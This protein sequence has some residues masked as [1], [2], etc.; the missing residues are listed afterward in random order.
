MKNFIARLSL[1]KIITFIVAVAIIVSFISYLPQTTVH[2]AD[3]P[4]VETK[5]V[6][7]AEGSISIEADEL[8]IASNG[9]REMYLDPKTLNTRIVDIASG[10]EFNSV[11]FADEATEAEHAP[12]ILTYMDKSGALTQWDAFTH[13]ID[14][15]TYSIDRIANGY[16]ATLHFTASESTV[17]NEFMPKEMPLERYEDFF[18]GGIDRMVLDG[19]ITEAD[20]ERYQKALRMIYNVQDDGN[21]YYNKYSGT[22]PVS[23]TNILI[24]LSKKLGY[25]TE[26]LIEDNRE[27][28]ITVE[29]K[30]PADFTVKMDVVLDNGDLCVSVPTHEIENGNEDYVVQNLALFPAFGLVDARDCDEGFIF[31][32]D[33]AGALFDI[34]T[35]DGNYSNYSRPVYN[36]TYYDNIYLASDYK[37]D[38]TM[39]VFGMSHLDAPKIEEAEDEDAEEGE[40][41]EEATEASEPQA[42]VRPAANVGF[43]GIIEEGALTSYVNVELGTKDTSGGGTNFNKVYPSFD[44]MQYSSVKVFGPYS[45]NDA[46]FL[47]TTD[48]YTMD[49]AVRY[50]FI[51]QDATYYAMAQE[52]RKYLMNKY[53]VSED[54]ATEPTL[55]LNV[56][57]AL[58]IKDRILGV[59]VNKKLSMTTYEEL[60]EILTDLVDVK[61]VV[62]YEGAFN[63]GIFNS[64][65]KS[66]GLVSVNGNA[67]ELTELQSKYS[68]SLYLEYAPARA[69][70]QKG[71][72]T[73]S[74]HALI[75]YDGEPLQIYDYNIP[76][77]QFDLSSTPYYLVHPAYLTAALETFV[78]SSSVSN[79]AVKDLGNLYYANYKADEQVSPYVGEK[80]VEDALGLLSA[81]GSI[82]LDNPNMNRIFYADYITDISR[83]SSDF[84]L[85]RHNVPFRQIVLNGLIPYSTLNVNMST[86]G[87]DYY[88]LQTLELGSNPKF[89]VTYKGVEI[90]KEA[91]FN[92]Y[93]STEYSILKDT[94]KSMYADAKDAFAQIGTTQIVN[95]EILEDNIYKTTYAT[96]VE[97]VTNYNTYECE[98]PYGTVGARHYKIVKGGESQ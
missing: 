85:F 65:N 71:G 3:L 11:T 59:P 15:E 41:A 98:T 38:L 5:T 19:E 7:A 12:L 63:G 51:G 8:L 69:Y 68:D 10:A 47:A 29:I 31:V 34:N 17:L 53:S 57:S 96:G 82:I 83:E 16:R 87:S 80:V 9:G 39:P 74:K 73:P 28:G 18:L 88:L 84:G 92:K 23:A 6:A 21:S 4:A 77:K 86:S 64:F 33:G 22:P 72:F 89:T 62:T 94:I 79:F 2:R 20:A 56:V 48:E 91:N 52:Y 44:T 58:D 26:M 54:F 55:F 32:P 45:T 30:T 42:P 67:R 60:A 36:N 14:M 50:K 49:C 24:D 37:E 46:R 90:L 70:S 27:Y 76:T 61:K 13:A 1:L 43:V 95:H 66:A 75:S 78:K 97:V 81:A 93:F 35:Y 40:E 25:T